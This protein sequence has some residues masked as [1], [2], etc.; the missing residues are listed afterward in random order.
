[1]NGPRVTSIPGM[2]RATTMLAVALVGLGARSV[3]AQY[4]QQTVIT[5]ER[6][7]A[8]AEWL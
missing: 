6:T 2:L 3:S 5:T 4:P 1:M 8:A 7:V